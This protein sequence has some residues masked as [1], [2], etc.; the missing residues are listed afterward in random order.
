MCARYSLE[1]GSSCDS[2]TDGSGDL[3]SNSGDWSSS[4]TSALESS[5]NLDQDKVTPTKPSGSAIQGSC[6]ETE[7]E[8]EG[9][10]S[11]SSHTP[12]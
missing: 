2:R 8:E 4:G 10:K 9:P 12:N 5:D 1:E 7:T 6:D 3:E 11:G